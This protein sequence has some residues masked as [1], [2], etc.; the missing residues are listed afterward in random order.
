[1]SLRVLS[2]QKYTSRSYNNGT[3]PANDPAISPPVF[4]LKAAAG[5]TFTDVSANAFTVS[6]VGG[7]TSSNSVAKFA[8]TYSA[9]F[10][11]TNYLNVPDA[12]ALRPGTGSFTWEFWWYPTALTSYRT[13]M[14]KGYTG[15]GDVLLQTGS[16]DG[17]L[18]AYL[19]GA[20]VL[21]AT[22]AVTVNTWNHVALVRNGTTLTWYINGTSAGSATN[23]TNLSST[24]GLNIGDSG[25]GAGGYLQD[26]RISNVA[27][28]TADFTTP[29]FSFS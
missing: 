18:I 9:S 1:M 8:S 3:N 5:N 19:S 22:T 26:V 20:A 7:V 15:G 14:A 25:Y 2:A 6:N 23:S 28:Y 10:S 27:R 13:P 16:G 4:L 11:T 29:Q 12:V 21:T 17:K 24:L